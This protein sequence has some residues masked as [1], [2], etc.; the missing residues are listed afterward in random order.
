MS[1]CKIIYEYE[2]IDKNNKYLVLFDKVCV[3]GP[4]WIIQNTESWT[5]KKNVNE[6]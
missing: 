5:H 2:D 6:I 4:I 3:D 1:G